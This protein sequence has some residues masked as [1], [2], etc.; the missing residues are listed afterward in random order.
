MG[1][2]GADTK[3]TSE[4]LILLSVLAKEFSAFREEQAT[5]LGRYQLSK[6]IKLQ[7]KSIEYQTFE[8]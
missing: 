3:D 7:S 5:R 6:A 4:I 1:S 8:G 2:E